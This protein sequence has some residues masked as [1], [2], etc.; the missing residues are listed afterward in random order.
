[1]RKYILFFTFLVIATSINAQNFKSDFVYNLSGPRVGVTIITNGD[2]T[3]KLNEEFGYTSN[4]I[5]QFGYQFETQI[6]GDENVA[7]LIEGI[8]FIGG[9]EHGLF[10]PSISGLFGARFGDGYEV[11]VGPNLSLAGAGLVLGVGKT[12]K[13]G[14]IN[15]PINFAWVPSTQRQR[16]VYYE[17]NSHLDDQGVWIDESYEEI[18]KYNTGHRFTF[19]IGFNYRKW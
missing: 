19:T 1:M 9:L 7:G 15:I 6:M 8:V 11:A 18:E 16:S 17:G 4:F 14:N 2:I 3:D 10:L 12:I 13:A 5:S